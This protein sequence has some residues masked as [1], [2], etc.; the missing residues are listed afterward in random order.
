[1]LW[2]IIG[3]I[4]AIW[5]IGLILDVAGGLIHI[6][7]IIAGIVFIFQLVTGKRKL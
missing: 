4:I 2:W 7:L 3:I 1:M 5:L 6:L